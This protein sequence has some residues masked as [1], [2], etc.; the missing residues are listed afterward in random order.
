LRLAGELRG[1]DAAQTIQ[2]HMAY[3]S[4]PPFDSGTPETA[5]PAILE[6]ALR[7]ARAI[8]AQREQTARRI[9]AKLVPAEAMESPV[10]GS[11]VRRERR[12]DWRT[13]HASGARL[14]N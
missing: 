10:G 12:M 3:A 9:A 7:S 5:P 8:T 11:R 1:D 13:R 2:R 14:I 4:E 6:K